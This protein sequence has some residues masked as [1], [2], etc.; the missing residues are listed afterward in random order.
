MIIS[1]GDRI[2]YVTPFGSAAVG[3]VTKVFDHILEVVED[4]GDPYLI[5]KDRV[6]DPD[7]SVGRRSLRVS[8]TDRFD[9]DYAPWWCRY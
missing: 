7:G 3:T 9:E 4:S 1:V 2:D 6:I 8:S 5:A